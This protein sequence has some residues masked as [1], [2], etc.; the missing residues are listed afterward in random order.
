MSQG[1]GSIH[2]G[3]NP[4]R[5][6]KRIKPWEKRR[7]TVAERA[8]LQSG[9]KVTLGDE[10]SSLTKMRMTKSMRIPEKTQV[11]EQAITLLHRRIMTA[12]RQELGRWYGTHIMN[13]VHKVHENVLIEVL[14]SN[15]FIRRMALP[16]GMIVGYASRSPLALSALTVAAPKSFETSAASSRLPRM[17]VKGHSCP[18]LVSRRNAMSGR[19]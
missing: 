7:A 17:M 9:D 2:T 10:I 6:G 1:S 14:F 13:S 3:Y 8:L 15:F 4:C 12:P 11:N 18:R 16:K 19:T 5:T